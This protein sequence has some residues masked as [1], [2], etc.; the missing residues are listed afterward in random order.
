MEGCRR[1]TKGRGA[2]LDATGVGRADGENKMAAGKAPGLMQMERRC[3]FPV[4]LPERWRGCAWRKARQRRPPPPS[5]PRACSGV[6]RPVRSRVRSPP[7]QSVA[8]R[9]GHA[10]GCPGQELVRAA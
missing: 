3:P 4:R 9:D 2:G 1:R 7:P 10:A 5:P 8:P 6:T